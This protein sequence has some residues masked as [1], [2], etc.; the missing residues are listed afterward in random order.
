MLPFVTVMFG[1]LHVK[2]NDA[3]VE[4]AFVYFLVSILPIK[5]SSQHI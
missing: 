3:F 2:D 1:R 4:K 5:I